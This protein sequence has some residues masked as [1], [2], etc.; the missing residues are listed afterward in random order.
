MATPANLQI[1]EDAINKTID[2][3]SEYEKALL[4]VQLNRLG[5]SLNHAESVLRKGPG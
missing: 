5:M 2:S 3:L 4:Y 1:I